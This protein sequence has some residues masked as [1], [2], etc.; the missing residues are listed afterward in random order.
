MAASMRTAWRKRG[1]EV[2][3]AKKDEDKKE[4]DVKKVGKKTWLKFYFWFKLD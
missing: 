2:G 4:K 3:A 1:E